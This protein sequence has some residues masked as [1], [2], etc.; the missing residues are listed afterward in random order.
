MQLENYDFS[1]FLIYHVQV[2]SIYEVTY[3]LKFLT[4][5]IVYHILQNLLP[6]SHAYS[7]CDIL[8]YI[9]E[10]LID[11][12]DRNQ[13]DLDQRISTIIEIYLVEFINASC[14]ICL[15]DY[16]VIGMSIN[17]ESHILLFYYYLQLVDRCQKI[18]INNKCYMIKWYRLPQ[19]KARS[20]IFPIIMSNY[21]VELTVGKMLKITMNIFS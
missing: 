18:G 5:C 3:I 19:N 8:A 20:L 12:D 6:N 10:D 11:G 2:S 4:C 7:Q 17:F 14:N 21:L 16:Y 9:L 13:S 15:L 1:D